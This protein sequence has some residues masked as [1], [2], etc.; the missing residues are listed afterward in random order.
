MSAKYN[1]TRNLLE[2][3]YGKL[4]VEFVKTDTYAALN[5]GENALEIVCMYNAL[6]NEVVSR[7]TQS[8]NKRETCKTI[9]D[10]ALNYITDQI[11]DFE[12]LL[13][14]VISVADKF[15]EWKG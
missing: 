7:H 5:M 9:R 12:S 2:N 13:K 3:K 4:P 6:H 8:F 15:E 11:N 14:N 10:E 1:D